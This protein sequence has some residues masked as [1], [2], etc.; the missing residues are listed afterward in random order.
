MI[1]SLVFIGVRKLK[2]KNCWKAKS[3]SVFILSLG[4]L[5]TF[6]FF[7]LLH[8]RSFELMVKSMRN[9]SYC[10]LY[11][12]SPH[13][14]YNVLII[15]VLCIFVIA[16][17]KTLFKHSLINYYSNQ[18]ILCLLHVSYFILPCLVS[19]IRCLG[20]FSKLFYYQQQIKTNNKKY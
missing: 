4:K 5:Y 18:D 12:F 1:K 17:C 6:H 20:F 3:C 2:M 14:E 16:V 19:Y 7:F 8:F 15:C 9:N 10:R 11:I 13:A